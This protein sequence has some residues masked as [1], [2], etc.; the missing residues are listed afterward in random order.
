M[1]VRGFRARV[2]RYLLVSGTA[3]GAAGPAE[4]QTPSPE[5]LRQLAVMD[6]E[7]A[8]RTPAQ[9]K[10]DSQLIFAMK[11]R[12]NDPMLTSM[13]QLRIGAEVRSDG[14]T[15][16]DLQGTVT[17]GVTAAIRRAGGR[18]VSSHPDA[19]ALRAWIPVMA[20]EAIAA[21]SDVRWIGPAFEHVTEV[22]SEGD[23]AHFAALTRDLFP[24]VSGAGVKICAMSDGV[25]RL[26]E[27]Q[28]A[29]ELPD[30]E[31]LPGKAG[32][33]AEGTAILEIIHDLAPGAA[34]GFATASGGQ[35]AF[36]ESIR[37]LR[38][39][40]GCDVIVDDI[41]YGD[42]PVFEDGPIAQAVSDV[43]QEGA[44][45]L[46]SAGN[47]GGV[48]RDQPVRPGAVATPGS[49]AVF[50]GDFRGLTFDTP[51]GPMLFNDFGGGAIT[52]QIEEDAQLFLLQ[53]SDPFGAASNDYDLIMT[54]AFL[55]RMVAMSNSIQ[56]GTQNPFEFIVS[57][58]PSN[59]MQNRD[60]RTNR[61]FVVRKDGSADRFIRLHAFNR[62]RLAIGTQGV[63][64]GHKGSPAAISVAAAFA[65]ENPASAPF[66]AG[67]V[68][69][70]SSEGPRRLFYR[71]EGG[72]RVPITPGNLLSTGGL[73][74]AKPDVAGA[75]GV[76]TSVVNLRMP[77]L[78]S[79][80]FRRFSGTSAAAPHVAAIAGLVLSAA[81]PETRPIVR[82]RLRTNM[83][84]ILAGTALPLQGGP[85][86]KGAGVV[87]ALA[88]VQVAQTQLPCFDDLDNDADGTIDGADPGCASLATATEAPPCN[89]GVD[90]DE[91]GLVDL[92]D[93]DCDAPSD[94]T[95]CGTGGAQSLAIVPLLAYL[96]RRRK[97]A[98]AA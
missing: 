41:A 25:E 62:G 64:F 61:L 11:R 69:P 94:G 80:N 76:T 90:N 7:K 95:E 28:Q 78:V 21:R 87:N 47:Q 31:V 33:G 17:P 93:T 51:Q 59:P 58:D 57:L 79:Q 48:G 83:K 34:L 9:R 66:P 1:P 89:D 56:S 52:N 40:I 63:I 26:V 8:Q 44:I 2:A 97:R 37:A 77:P 82:E 55:T 72:V 30:V 10:L 36:A 68:E 91:D 15:L 14:A 12:R 32:S 84:Q 42:A 39:Q 96:G 29:G 81:P 4:A 18:V 43:T 38:R 65:G 54:D 45:Y 92:Q 86:D 88:A 3:L 16:V 20:L 71:R 53:W 22:V 74:V 49:A 5:L 46:T 24:G 60:D 75:D 6:Q 98:H 73:L 19:G 67:A 35:P 85:F 27:S 50:E 23:S 70:F 13:P